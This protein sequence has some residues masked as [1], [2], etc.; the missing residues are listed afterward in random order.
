MSTERRNPR[1]VDI[2]LFPIERVLK[3][4]N[5]EDALVPGAVAAAIPD[6]A[7][8]IQIAVMAIRSGG[9]IFYVGAGTSG[10]IA[11]MD[12]VECPPTFSTP[13]HWF[14]AILAGGSKAVTH[15]QEDSE[16]DRAKGTADVKAKK[17]TSNDVVIGVAASGATPYTH[18]A[19]EF[20]K[21]KGAKTVALVAQSG[22]LMSKTA[23]ITI[24]TAVGPEIITGSSR[25]KAGT[26]QK[27]VLNMISTAT[28]VRLGMTYSNWM[29]NVSMTN[30]KLRERGMQ[31]LQEILGVHEEEAR[32]L[33]EKSG[34]NLKIAVIMGAT[35]C[36]HTQ[37]EKL[38][39]NSDGNLRK[40]VAHLGSGRE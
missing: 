36:D 37:A 39:A 32:R 31:T 8:V 11:V 12:A 27:L 16:D 2:D 13:P 28:M 26:A 38:L 30:Q 20:A 10:R 6:I 29:I 9:R 24:C 1:S 25:M 18:A 4:I 33:I 3:I 22:S 34:N 15:A 21:S 17:I 19:L 5:A 35:G 23:D 14:Q 7:K 40:I